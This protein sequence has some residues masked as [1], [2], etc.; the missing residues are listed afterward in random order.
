MS[1][2]LNILCSDKPYYCLKYQI[3]LSTMFNYSTQLP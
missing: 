1:R 2:H 3:N